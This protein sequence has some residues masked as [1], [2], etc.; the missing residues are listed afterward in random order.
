MKERV[1]VCAATA[2]LHQASN[3][4]SGWSNYNSGHETLSLG[5]LP[6]TKRRPEA[7]PASGKAGQPAGS[8]EK[9]SE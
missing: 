2:E 5:R 3:G 6:T 4:P 9:S 7:G 1:C 8:G